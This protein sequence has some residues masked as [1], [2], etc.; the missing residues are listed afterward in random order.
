MLSTKRNVTCFWSSQNADRHTVQVTGK[1]RPTEGTRNYGRHLKRMPNYFLLELSVK[2]VTV[3]QCTP[4]S[5]V[6]KF[7]IAA[8]LFHLND[9]KFTRTYPLEEIIPRHNFTVQQFLFCIWVVKSLETGR[10]NC[11]LEGHYRDFFKSFLIRALFALLRALTLPLT[12]LRTS[13]SWTTSRRQ[14]FT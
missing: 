13:W 10:K 11:Y 6:N 2:G 4:Q 3:L 7:A 14:R 1:Y 5:E 8:H 12:N 9:H